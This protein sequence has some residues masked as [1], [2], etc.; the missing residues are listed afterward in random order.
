MPDTGILAPRLSSASRRHRRLLFLDA[1][2]HGIRWLGG[3][4]QSKSLEDVR[5]AALLALE[6][7]AN[8]RRWRYY[9]R[10]GR[11]ILTP[12]Y[13]TGTVA[14]TNSTRLMTLTGGTWPTNVERGWVRINNANHKV[15]KRVSSTVIRLDPMN[16]PG[17][18][19]AS[20]TTYQWYRST[21]ELPPDFLS[22]DYVLPES[23]WWWGAQHGTP[24]GML[25]EDRY[26]FNSGS[27]S[28]AFTIRGDASSFGALS[29]EVNG[30]PAAG[31]TELTLDFVYMAMPYP[32]QVDGLLTQD[33]AGKVSTS[34][35]S[36][37]I[38]GVSSEFNAIHQGSVIRISRNSSPP[39]GIEGNNRYDMEYTVETVNSTLS[40]DVIDNDTPSSTVTDRGYVISDQV[41]IAAY[42]IPAYLRGVEWQLAQNRNMQIASKVHEQ[43]QMAYKR[44]ASVDGSLTHQRQT[45]GEVYNGWMH[46]LGRY[47]E[48][49]AEV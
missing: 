7:L 9:T 3:N 2:E 42:M 11:V 14:Y 47:G 24:T 32:L 10:S 19:L 17:L 20:G 5:E 26:A 45:A 15:D 33:K 36:T 27:P 29:L 35:S 4:S 12:M 44:A 8:R 1:I 31:E 34:A 22:L 13:E 38:T 40:L 23:S 39:T 25:T 30:F 28:T 49:G 16:N 43:Y 6:E 46:R 41:D 48:T 37:A 21:Y 18:D